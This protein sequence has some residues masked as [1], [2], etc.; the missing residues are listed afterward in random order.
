MPAGFEAT[1]RPRFGIPTAEVTGAAFATELNR[2]YRANLIPFRDGWSRDQYPLSFE[3]GI[4][5]VNDYGDGCRGIASSQVPARNTLH[6]PI[7]SA[8]MTIRELVSE[9]W[10]RGLQDG[11]EPTQSQALMCCDGLVVKGLSVSVSILGAYNEANYPVNHDP[12]TTPP[13][14][15]GVVLS[16]TVALKTAIEKDE[17]TGAMLTV[18]FPF[19]SDAGAITVENPIVRNFSVLKRVDGWATFRAT[20]EGIAGNTETLAAGQTHLLVPKLL[21]LADITGQSDYYSLERTI[22]L[23]QD[24]PARMTEA[25]V[26]YPDADYPYKPA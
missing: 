24:A 3:N 2:E 1:T 8:R 13:F 21:L 7:T 23:S 20:L 22:E 6:V 26:I 25:A 15:I 4:S 19:T 9:P 11:A 12:D 16:G 18:G 5:A 10:M 17:A 14:N